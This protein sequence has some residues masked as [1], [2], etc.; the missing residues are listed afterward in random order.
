MRG[1]QAPYPLAL[2]LAA[3]LGSVAACADDAG[4][5]DASACV[6]GQYCVGNQTCVNGFC[7][8]LDGETGDG[9]TAGDGD[10]DA[11]GDGDGDGDAAGDGDGDGD[12]AGDGDGEPSTLC[13][14]DEFIAID[15]VDADTTVGWSVTGSGF[16]EGVVLSWDHENPEAYAEW[17]F[18]IP[19]DA[20]WHV[21]VRALN[22]DEWDSFNV[23]ID[24]GPMP[25]PIFEIA[26]DAGP[27]QGAYQWRELNLRDPMSPTCEYVED[28]WVQAWD[29]GPHTL[30]LGYRECYGI[31][32]IWLTNTD[33]SPP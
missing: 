14:G 6:G 10:G 13:E 12:A 28:P 5:T 2:V 16:E 31:S 3:M 15:A 4:S 11:A 30:T 33:Q 20:D 8:P 29:A 9:D 22:I 18:D 1:V 19:C 25:T 21:W 26:C 27:A 32:K 17:N 24:G 23:Q 7:V